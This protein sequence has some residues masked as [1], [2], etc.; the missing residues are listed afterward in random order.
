MTFPGGDQDQDH[1]Q[2][3]GDALE[4][5]GQLSL[6]GEDD[7][8]PWLEGDEDEAEPASD[9]RILVFAA[10]A[11]IALLAILFGA[12]QFFS[13]QGAGDAAPDGSTIEAPEGA[14][15]MRPSDPGGEDVAGTGD[16]SFEVGE[17]EGREGRIDNGEPAPSIDVDGQEAAPVASASARPTPTASSSAAPSRTTGVGVQVGAYS[18]R[19][20]AEAG[21]AQLSGRFDALQGVSHRVIEGTADSGTIFR[22]QAIAANVAAA[23]AMCRSIRSGGGDCQVKR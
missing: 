7:V 14:Y 11:A 8:L 3:Q 19:A 21:W 18:S 20:A 10:L 4:P 13:R 12:W 17:G 9:Y 1:V 6:T 22:L 5:A 2:D 16:L 15:K 23:E